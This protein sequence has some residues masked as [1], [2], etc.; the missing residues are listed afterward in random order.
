MQFMGSDKLLQIIR[1][2]CGDWLR[3]DHSVRYLEMPYLILVGDT[4]L[5]F[6][7]DSCVGHAVVQYGIQM[8]NKASGNGTRSFVSDKRTRLLMLPAATVLRLVPIGWTGHPNLHGG[9]R[10]DQGEHQYQWHQGQMYFTH[11]PRLLWW[12]FSSAIHTLTLWYMRIGTMDSLLSRLLWRR[13]TK[14]PV[15]LYAS[16]API[17]R[18]CRSTHRTI[19][20][21]S[22]IHPWKLEICSS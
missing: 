12:R 16:L 20:T 13:C 17:V 18:M 2:M 3:L 10:T 1:V 15:A 8:E 5:L 9:A 11:E 22:S 6:A 7:A 21:W 19:T 4:L 14:A